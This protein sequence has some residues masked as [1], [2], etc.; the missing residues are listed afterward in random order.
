MKPTKAPDFSP[1][2][3]VHDGGKSDEVQNGRD[4]ISRNIWS[5]GAAPYDHANPHVFASISI[6]LIAVSF[7]HSPS[8]LLAV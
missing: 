4:L 8:L 1:N 5:C 6:Q 3:P 2:E 7:S